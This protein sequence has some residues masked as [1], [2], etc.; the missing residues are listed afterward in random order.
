MSK[1]YPWPAKKGTDK[2]AQQ[3]RRFQRRER[4]RKWKEIVAHEALAR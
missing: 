2:Q 4:I 3:R 1:H